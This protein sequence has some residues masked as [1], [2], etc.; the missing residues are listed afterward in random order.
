MRKFAKSLGDTNMD[1]FFFLLYFIFLCSKIFV[2]DSGGEKVY[3]PR[4]RRL[5]PLRAGSVYFPPPRPMPA[6]KAFETPPLQH[7]PPGELRPPLH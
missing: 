1:A 4:K 2:P 5:E 6:R 7:H 3:P